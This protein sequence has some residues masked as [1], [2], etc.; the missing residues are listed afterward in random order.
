MVK[1][2]KKVKP[3]ILHKTKKYLVSQISKIEFVLVKTNLFMYLPQV[4]EANI[5]I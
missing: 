2:K 1:G 3:V 4:N 5:K